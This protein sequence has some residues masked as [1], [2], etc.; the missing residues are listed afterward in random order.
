MVSVVQ[1]GHSGERAGARLLRGRMISYESDS[2]LL[3][4]LSSLQV[5]ILQ[6]SCH[7]PKDRE[8]DPLITYCFPFSWQPQQQ[9][10]NAPDALKMQLGRLPRSQRT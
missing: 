4:S 7:E 1:E 5:G 6:L 8:P 2:C 3:D 9:T 10:V